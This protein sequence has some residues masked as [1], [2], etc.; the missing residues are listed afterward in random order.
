M[1][2]A[3]PSTPRGTSLGPVRH[4]GPFG[5][6]G[7]VVSL[8]SLRLIALALACGHGGPRTPA[9]TACEG[10]SIALYDRGAGG[11]YGVVDDRR[12][13]ETDGDWLVLD[14]VDPGAA[15]SSLVIEPLAGGTLE[16]GA[17]LRD[18]IPA[19]S[20]IA[21]AGA[22]PARAPAT[23][24][25]PVLRCA[26]HAR[27]GR[28]LVRVLYV[29]PALGYRA[30]HD[31][32]MTAPDRA[33]VASRFAV[34]TPAWQTTA[35]VTLFDGLPGSDQ[36]PREVARGTIRLDGETAVLAVRVREAGA[37]LRWVYR[38][39]APDSDDDERHESQ[40]AVWVWLEL[41]HLA[42]A[43]GPVRAHVELA[44]Q[45]PR[46]ID[47]PAA[48][49]RRA[50]PLLRLPL[51]I[52]DQLRG[53]RDR[54]IGARGDG[55]VTDKVTVSVANTGEVTRDVWIEE[56]LRPARS[57]TVTRAWPGAPTIAGNRLR[58]KL[59]VPGGKIER[60]GLEIA[61]GR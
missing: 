30:E 34:A 40:P 15:L 5:S 38:G 50:G 48:G 46:D 9:N 22:K 56:T 41:D 13:I 47:V 21:V 8:V 49:R 39:A 35:E 61:Y 10:V 20:S 4:R 60:G 27:R 44:G 16:T 53:K 17:C 24:F 29:S 2:G 57:R 43:P 28:Y 25:A 51:W 18:R 19:P 52:D 14:R 12:W 11:A 6:V 37:E 23:R 55:T 26:V 1:S 45:A 42:L 7:S 31:I 32:A 54:W 36:P 59:T 33:R 3:A 58:M